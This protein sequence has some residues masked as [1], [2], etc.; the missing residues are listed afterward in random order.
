MHKPYAPYLLLPS[1]VDRV[2]VMLFPPHPTQPLPP[3]ACPGSSAPRPTPPQCHTWALPPQKLVKRRVDLARRILLA[4]ALNFLCGRAR[5]RSVGSSTQG[6]PPVQRVSSGWER[7]GAR[8]LAVDSWGD[9]ESVDSWDRGCF[10]KIHAL[11]TAPGDAL[12]VPLRSS[13]PIREIY[14]LLWEICVPKID[15]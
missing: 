15:F 9:E 11:E 7:L 8:A 12:Y 13:Q 1:E 3:P 10:R 14:V 2:Q 6:A 5:T 4:H